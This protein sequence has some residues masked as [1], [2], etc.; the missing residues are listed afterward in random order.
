M[1]VR[2][3]AQGV[4]RF[5]DFRRDIFSDTIRCAG[6][7]LSRQSAGLLTR[8]SGVRVPHGPRYQGED[9]EVQGRV[10]LNGSSPRWIRPIVMYLAPLSPALRAVLIS[11][12]AI[13]TTEARIF[14]S[15][16]VGQ[17]GR[18]RRFSPL[19]IIVC[20]SVRMA[21]CV[22]RGVP[23]TQGIGSPIIPSPAPSRAHCSIT[24]RSSVGSGRR[25]VLP[26]RRARHAAVPYAPQLL[27][28][29]ITR[30]S[31]LTTVAMPLPQGHRQ[32][33]PYSITRRTVS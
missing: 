24:R 32:V 14:L 3:T 5:E 10:K 15:H 25:L 17:K 26:W 9:V 8:A 21:V 1:G 7:Y 19:E 13:P 12:W 11:G 6:R 4:A 22:S 33:D 28:L 20:K 2:R 31:V 16:G 30:I 27:V 18:S 23:S 29:A